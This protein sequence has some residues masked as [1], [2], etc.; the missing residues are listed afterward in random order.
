MSMVVWK[1]RIAQYLKERGSEIISSLT[2]VNGSDITYENYR[3]FREEMGRETQ[4]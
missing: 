1:E 2:C 4:N 3:L